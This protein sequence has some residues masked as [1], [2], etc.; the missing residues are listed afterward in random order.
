M[1][2][3]TDLAADQPQQAIISSYHNNCPSKTTHSPKKVPWWNEKLS[4]LR[5]KTKRSFNAAKMTGQW[6]AYKQPSS[7]TTKK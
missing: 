3:D 5:A 1:I 6:D 2:R 4:G 7:V